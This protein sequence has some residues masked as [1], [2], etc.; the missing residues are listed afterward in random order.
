MPDLH[1][2]EFYKDTALVLAQLYGAFPR[3]SSVYVEDIAGD[4]RPDE[5]GLHSKRHLACF[6]AMLW[7]AEEGWL[8]YVDTIGQLAID[9]ATL[10]ER[11]FTV[12]SSFALPESGTAAK[13]SS[14]SHGE[15]QLQIDRLRRALNSGNTLTISRVVR[16]VIFPT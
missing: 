4:D 5:F 10:T 1:I 2:D 12:L 7:L 14:A 15:P 13:S 9:Q 3:K 11:A 8:R 16:D 6:G